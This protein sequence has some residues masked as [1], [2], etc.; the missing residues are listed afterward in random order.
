MKTYPAGTKMQFGN[1]RG[2]HAIAMLLAMWRGR[3]SQVPDIKPLTIIETGTH[4]GYMT[5]LLWANL[6]PA[7][8]V[9]LESNAQ[10]AA[11]ASGVLR[12]L[13]ARTDRGLGLQVVHGLSVGY[14]EALAFLDAD[15]M[16]HAPWEYPEVYCDPCA[17][18]PVG[19]GYASEVP[20]DC[21]DDL[22][23]KFLTP[24]RDMEPL[25]VLD[26]CGGLGL[27]E[28]HIVQEI[29]GPRPYALLLDD[30]HHVKHVRTIDR[31]LDDES[32]AVSVSSGAHAWACAVRQEGG[33]Q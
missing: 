20:N 14:Q 1:A 32:F 22:L 5:A 33:G 7:T 18:D 21:A 13:V 29:M 10:S 31:L 2:A 8:L 28:Y 25:V 16:L 17:L 24:V 9:S 12:H 30:V 23:E 6:M 11:Y 15:S 27:L 3:M 19:E 26:S 4:Q